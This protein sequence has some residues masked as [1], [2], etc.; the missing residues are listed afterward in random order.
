MLHF[1]QLVLGAKQHTYPAFSTTG[2]LYVFIDIEA[3]ILDHT[4]QF[5]E[6][7]NNTSSVLSVM[8][9]ELFLDLLQPDSQRTYVLR[10]YQSIICVLPQ[11]D[12]SFIFRITT[13]NCPP[14]ESYSFL[15]FKSDTG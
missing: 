15:S 8:L 12:Q 13:L 2:R 4:F 6:E 10:Y 7:G 5:L 14:L 1:W 9:N 11:L 3:E